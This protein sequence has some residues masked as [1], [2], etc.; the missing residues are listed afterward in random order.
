MYIQDVQSQRHISGGRVFM[1]GTTNVLGRQCDAF[2]LLTG[3]V[4]STSTGNEA[5]QLVPIKQVSA[6]G[7]E[8]PQWIPH[9]YVELY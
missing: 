6:G 5:K 1:A 2:T 9:I 8:L 3:F 4:Y 7:F